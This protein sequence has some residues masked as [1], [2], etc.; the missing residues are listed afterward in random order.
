MERKPD[1]FAVVYSF[2]NNYVLLENEVIPRMQKFQDQV[3]LIVVDDKSCKEEYVRGLELC[4]TNNII[5]L[6]NQ[7]KGVANA[8]D[9][10]VKYLQHNEIADRDWIFCAQQDIYPKEPSFF[11]Q[12]RKYVELIEGDSLVGAV[13][14][15]ALDEYYSGDSMRDGLLGSFFLSKKPTAADRLEFICSLKILKHLVRSPLDLFNTWKRFNGQ[16][17]AFS[18][19]TFRN[20]QKIRNLYSATFAIELPMWAFVA[21][22]LDSWRVNIRPTTGLIF[23]LWFNDVAMQFLSQ[24]HQILVF[25]DLYLENDQQIKTKYGFMANS[26]DAGRNLQLSQV[27]QYGNHLEIFRTRWGFDYESPWKF[28]RYIKDRYA[29]TLV[30]AHFN[31]D[32]RKGPIHFTS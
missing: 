10:A 28:S 14:F 22:N 20:F 31:H 8:V 11:V 18:P 7:G 27:E 13:G 3:I 6:Q 12:F 23:H 19:R 32:I 1:K 24:S 25:P 9:T 4:H 17:R 16:K 15:N 30:A 29:G 2:F 26:A 21:I 5:F